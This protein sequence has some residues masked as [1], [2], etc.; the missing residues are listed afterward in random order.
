MHA[1]PTVIISLI[2]FHRRQSFEFQ[3]FPLTSKPQISVRALYIS[4][5][6]LFHQAPNLAASLYVCSFFFFIS[7]H[8]CPSLYLN[9][10]LCWSTFPVNSPSVPFLPTATLQM[11]LS[12][13][14]TFPFLLLN[15]TWASHSLKNQVHNC[16]PC[17]VFKLWMI[18]LFSSHSTCLTSFTFSRFSEFSCLQLFQ[19]DL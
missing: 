11:I 15:L 9:N 5:L 19:I 1:F 7:P 12:E 4:T 18:L 17:Q 14:L 10:S 16:C 3:S 8:H 13:V 6:Y 2:V